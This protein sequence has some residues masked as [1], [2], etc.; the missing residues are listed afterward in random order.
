[1][2]ARPGGARFVVRFLVK[3]FALPAT[4]IVCWSTDT[5]STTSTG[6]RVRNSRI[7]RENGWQL[8]VLANLN[9]SRFRFSPAA[10]MFVVESRH[11]TI[12]VFFKNRT[13][14]ENQGYSIGSE[15]TAEIDLA[16]EEDQHANMQLL[17]HA[18]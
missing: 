18:E 17:R 5:R 7:W 6:R 15:F 12:M 16:G 1:M 2:R 11:V 3:G 14:D 8:A 4:F 10:M 9:S 13:A